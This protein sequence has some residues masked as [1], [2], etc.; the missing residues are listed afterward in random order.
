MHEYS[1]VQ[2]LL[3]RVDEVAL[4]RGAASVQRL[5]VRIGD[6]SGVEIPLLCSAFEVFRAHTV[7]AAAELDV[8]PV[9]AH[10]ACPGCGRGFARGEVLR[11]ADCGLPARLDQ[12]DEIIL[13]RIEME[14]PDV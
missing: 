3:D 12:G 8:Q 7:C 6:L 2:S 4:S 5:T 10:W 14:V 13:E 11:C 1:I 9:P